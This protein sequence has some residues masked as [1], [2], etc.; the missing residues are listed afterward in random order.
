MVFLIRNFK[1]KW[2]VFFSELSLGKNS[3][4]YYILFSNLSRALLLLHK[5]E[6]NSGI[7]FAFE[8]CPLM[9]FWKFFRSL[10]KSNK[11]YFLHSLYYFAIHFFCYLS[12]SSLAFY[13][14]ICLAVSYMVSWT[15]VLN[16]SVQMKLH[17]PTSKFISV[18]QRS[19]W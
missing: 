15:V 7:N 10:V 19:I 12:D 16:T 18:L 2:H 14:F 13:R 9:V 17:W 5:E 4:F 11:Q 3:Y 6:W 1:D 8:N